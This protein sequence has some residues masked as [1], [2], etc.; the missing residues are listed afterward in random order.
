MRTQSYN[1]SRRVSCARLRPC[2]TN[3]TS[4]AA[5]NASTACASWACA[6]ASAICRRAGDNRRFTSRHARCTSSP[7]SSFELPASSFEYPARRG[8]PH[9]LRP[10]LGAHRPLPSGRAARFGGVADRRASGVGRAGSERCPAAPGAGK[11]RVHRHGDDR[12]VV[13]R[14]HVHVSHRC[15][16][17]RRRDLRRP[18]VLYAQPGR[19]ARPTPPGGRGAGTLHRHRQL[20]RPRLRHAADQQ[21]LR[22]GRYAVCP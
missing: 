5:S 17:V 3:K 12:S 16:D 14:R 2:P 1:L 15:R 13:G 18:P 6:A 9:P 21:P 8:S 19:G 22:A 10:G 11:G 7:A 20:Q 4:T